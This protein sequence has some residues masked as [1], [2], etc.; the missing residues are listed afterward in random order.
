MKKC[1]SYGLD[2][3]RGVGDNQTIGFDGSQTKS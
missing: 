3:E 2:D 1:W